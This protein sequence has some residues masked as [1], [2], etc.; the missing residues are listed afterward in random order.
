[1]ATFYVEDFVNGHFVNGHSVNGHFDAFLYQKQEPIKELIK[2]EE[3]IKEEPTLINIIIKTLTGK[4]IALNILNTKTILDLKKELYKL[5]EIFLDDQRY[6]FNGSQLENDYTISHYNISEGDT[7]NLVLRLRGGMFHISSARKDYANISS[8]YIE[9]FQITSRMLQ[10]LKKY[11]IQVE[12]INDL[13]QRLI[14]TKN[15]EEINILHD[16]I[17]RVYVK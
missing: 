4:R 9:K 6:I 10:E 14:Y 11:N 2:E 17:K 16:L 7:I 8:N 13:E 15:D 5:E 3:P 1:M 12:L